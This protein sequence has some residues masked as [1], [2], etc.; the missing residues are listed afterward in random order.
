MA[1]CILDDIDQKLISLLKR[2]ARKP[3]VG[4]AKAVGLS[5]SA[6]QGRLARLEREGTIQGYTAVLGSAATRDTRS[7]AI[8]LLTI[9]SRPC[10]TVI[11]RFRDWP[12][13]KACW[14]VAGPVVDAVVIVETSG[15][16]DLG[17]VRTR[18]A[19]IPGVTGI[20]TAPVLKTILE[21]F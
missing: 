7:K 8:L 20:T 9:G 18:I 21:N 12:E 4:L 2:D 5:R 14:S 3:V 6:V 16:E 1:A 11:E 19:D 15:N 17:A 13:I 10:A